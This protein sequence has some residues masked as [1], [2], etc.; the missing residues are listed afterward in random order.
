[1]T[2]LAH[3]RVVTWRNHLRRYPLLHRLY[4][5]WVARHDYEERFA[6]GLLA[7][8]APGDTVWDVGANV[9]LYAAQFLA[10][11]AAHVVC[12]EPAPEA[13]LRLEQTFGRGTAARERVHIVPAALSNVRGTVR[14]AVNGS[15]PTNKIVDSAVVE[16]TIEVPVLRGDEVAAERGLPLPNVIKIDVEG[17]EWEV[18]Q[19]LAG[20]LTLPAVHAV[21]IEVHF[22]LLH[23]RGLDHAPAAISTTLAEHGFDVAWLDPSHLCGRRERCADAS[24]VRISGAV[25]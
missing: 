20:I 22:A 19:G 15:S 5:F 17:Y 21:F 16:S 24:A 3:P 25:A 11:Q 23:G 8:V 18:L 13:V 12:F 7:A 2:L 6:R 10:R 14:F 4:R 9:G 1:L